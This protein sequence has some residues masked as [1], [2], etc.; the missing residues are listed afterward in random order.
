VARSGPGDVIQL[1]G[2][3]A[4]RPE[5]LVVVAVMRD[6]ATYRLLADDPAQ[7][8]WYRCFRELVDGDV[9]WEDTELDGGPV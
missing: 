2:H 3:A 6:E 1:V 5:D 7:N 9:R 4:G 8:A